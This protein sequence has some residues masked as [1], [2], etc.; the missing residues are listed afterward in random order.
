ML[1]SSS[2][3]NYAL[4]EHGDVNQYGSFAIPSETM[5]YQSY[6]EDLWNKNEIL[7]ELPC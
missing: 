6:S 4:N 5:L 1:M 7:I 2:G 3:T